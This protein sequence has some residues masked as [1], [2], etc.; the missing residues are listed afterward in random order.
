MH[1]EPPTAP[2]E[3]TMPTPTEIIDLVSAQVLDGVKK[4]QDEAVKAVS[5]WTETIEGF[6]PETITSLDAVEGLPR[7]ATL[8]ELAFDF[9]QKVLEYQFE[10]ARSVAGIVGGVFGESAPAPAAEAPKAA[11][12]ATKAPSTKAAA[13]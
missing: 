2:Q 7:P 3:D 8:V 4:S 6:L 5:T 12:K 9:T 1:A 13:K 11:P 10:L